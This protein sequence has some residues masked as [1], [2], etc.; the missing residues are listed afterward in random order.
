MLVE[1]RMASFAGNQ[2]IVSGLSMRFSGSVAY[3]VETVTCKLPLVAIPAL[4]MPTTGLAT[5]TMALRNTVIAVLLG[6]T[7]P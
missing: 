4:V 7:T 5:R 2:L 1:I 6:S 3:P